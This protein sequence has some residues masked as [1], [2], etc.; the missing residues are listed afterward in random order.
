MAEDTPQDGDTRR[1]EAPEPARRLRP[2]PTIELAA[3]RVGTGGADEPASTPEDPAGAAAP[4]K[5]ARGAGLA[6]ALLA[7][8][9]AG[10]VV[11]GVVAW[12]GAGR[13]GPVAFDS[14]TVA[15]LETLGARLTRLETAPPP[16]PRPD[17]TTTARLDGLDKTLA[18][19]RE[20][21]ETVRGHDEALAQAVEALKAQPHEPAAAVPAA[22]PPAA[23]ADA[24]RL[25]QLDAAVKAV[26]AEVERLRE[27]KPAPPPPPPAD[28]VKA[29]DIKA[30]D[31]ALRRA[32]DALA[33]DLAV[34]QGAPYAAELAALREAT[35]DKRGDKSGDKSG[36][37]DAALAPL[38]RFA[39]SGVPDGA[40]LARELTAALP[41]DHAPE[42]VA[43]AV[44]GGWFERLEAGA[45]RLIKLRRVDDADGGDA[46]PAGLARVAAAAR[47]GDTTA[48][49]REIAA[50]PEAQ[51]GALQAWLDR[52]TAREAALAAA[53]RAVTEAV[54]ALAKTSAP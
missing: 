5:P 24:E 48:A 12:V 8:A 31:L 30:S 34:R 52:V 21:L 16:A 11:G 7:G 6:V 15:T 1:D 25:A 44:R 28:E 37:D 49:R 41:K 50:L 17:P 33:L 20:Q 4:V 39:D 18:S 47:H 35:G 46:A 42:P 53:H 26:T 36:D 29:S 43:S 22:E 19:L 2:P 40:Q 27:A 3:E 38:D 10:G 23:A 13:G 32:V 45:A 54:A 9:V 14:S 51:R